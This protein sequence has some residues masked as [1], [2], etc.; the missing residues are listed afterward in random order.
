MA[1][2]MRSSS[3]SAVAGRRA[4]APARAVVA[5]AGGNWAPGTPKPEWLPADMPGNFGFDPLGLGKDSK[6]LERFQESE[7]YHGRW[8]MLGAA[9][10]LAVELAGQGNWYDA[11]TWAVTGGTATYLGAPVPFDLTTITIFEVVGMAFAE[12]KR[13]EADWNGRV[14]PGFDPAGMAKDPSKFAEMKVKEIKNGRLAMVAFI[15]FIG[16]HAATG[17]SPLEALGEHVAN[18]WAVNF[19]TNGV[20][21]PGL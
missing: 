18:P 8:A 5:R 11:P 2:S 3:S 15:G 19:A 17:K 10:C 9:G 7:I 4:A 12:G 1:L 13:A 16:Q 21:I 20:S 14:Y 6:S